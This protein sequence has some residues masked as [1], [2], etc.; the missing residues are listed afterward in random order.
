MK[1]R[2]LAILLAVLMLLSVLTA[3]GNKAESPED[4]LLEDL[5]EAAPETPETPDEPAPETSDEPAVDAV[6][7]KGISA[8]GVITA[9]KNTYDTL[10]EYEA[11]IGQELTM[12]ESPILAEKVAAGE[13][14]AVED[15]LPADPLVMLPLSTEKT[16]GNKRRLASAAINDMLSDVAAFYGFSGRADIQWGR[17]SANSA[18]ENQEL[19]A[20]YQAG[21]LPLREYLRRRW[22]DLDEEEVEKMAREVEAEQETRRKAES[23]DLFGDVSMLGGA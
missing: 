1:R 6:S 21:T 10:S 3:C 12:T 15:R 19:L 4:E 20:D 22:S 23:S 11:Y 18:R 7:I 14:P 16:V 17:T 13:L 2:I 9:E 5:Q 8:D